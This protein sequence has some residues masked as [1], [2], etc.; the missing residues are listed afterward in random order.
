MQ[1][2]RQR[3]LLEAEFSVGTTLR[4]GNTPLWESKKIAR[5]FGLESLWIKDES[6]NPFGTHKDRKSE[7]VVQRLLAQP[8]AERPKALCIF[9]SGNA[10]VSLAR[11]ANAIG[12]AV[13]CLVDE[14]HISDSSLKGIEEVAA[15]IVPIAA[16]E[17]R[18]TSEELQDVASAAYGGRVLDVTNC[19]EAYGSIADEMMEHAPDTIVVPVGSGELFMGIRDRLVQLGSR[20]KLIGITV[21]QRNSIADK[22]Y[23]SWTPYRAELLDICSAGLH[24]LYR[25]DENR[26]LA[27]TCRFVSRYLLCEPSSATAFDALSQLTFQSRERLV[28]INTGCGRPFLQETREMPKRPE[29]K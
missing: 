11:F 21:T 22:L 3:A 27:E 5:H 19:R 2:N 15:A 13:V 8:P 25:T 26:R 23:A 16:S 18:W 1:F 28:V 14:T 10:G 17:R 6:F 20:I 4:S 24:E 12:V 7:Y 29:S 9:T